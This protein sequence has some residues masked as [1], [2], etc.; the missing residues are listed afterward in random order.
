MKK[1]KEIIDK[2][3]AFNCGKNLFFCGVNNSLG[4]IPETEFSVKRINEIDKDSENLLIDYATDKA[5][6]EFYRINQYYTFDKQAKKDLREIYVEL[7]LKFRERKTSIKSI[8]GSH[9]ENLSKWLLLSNPFAEKIYL[10]KDENVESAACSEYS[11]D[12]QMEILQID[13]TKIMEPVLDIGC[14]E[15]GNLVQYFCKNRIEAVGFDISAADKSYIAKSDWFEYELGINRWGT[16]T[17]NLGFS[18]HFNHH[19]LRNDGNFIDYANKFMDILNS[20]KAGGSF[21][22][23]PDLPFIE[24]YLDENKYQITKRTIGKYNFKSTRIKRLE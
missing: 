10:S 20:L 4:F 11:P 22:Y 6:R 9:Y 18:N 17:S 24:K 1:F 19:H 16:I 2:Q 8:S 13:I 7:F 15:Q 3:V 21:H 14:G 5:L 12:I 23:A